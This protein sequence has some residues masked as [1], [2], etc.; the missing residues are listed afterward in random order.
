MSRKLSGVLF[1]I[2]LSLLLLTG[3]NSCREAVMHNLSESDA[4]RLL[5]NLD[6][7]Q[8]DSRKVK[9][10]DGK[11]LVEVP[12]AKA[13]Q[14]I[15][16]LD[17]SR[18]FKD[19]KPQQ[20]GKASMIVSREEQRAESIRML[21]REIEA[22]LT[23]I[24][25]VLEA[26]VHLQLPARDPFFGEKVLGGREGSAAVLLVSG[27]GFSLSKED[28]QALIAGA[29]GIKPE[30]IAVVLTRSFVQ[31]NKNKVAVGLTT[32]GKQESPNVGTEEGSVT[33]RK[34]WWRRIASLLPKSETVPLQLLLS[35]FILGVGFLS[36]SISWRR[37]RM[38][39][40]RGLAGRFSSESVGGEGPYAA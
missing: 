40:L 14:A 13:L 38:K 37:G 30:Q 22:T 6:S 5:T 10:P 17:Q 2:G 1:R 16:F 9:Q 24:D 27:K 20:A 31:D 36:W 33:N 32:L 3:L 11:W 28:V 34:E 19:I 39:K 12:K 15:R 35:L 21:S 29:A 7:I 18:L 25:G 4:N 26:H 8:I 23:S